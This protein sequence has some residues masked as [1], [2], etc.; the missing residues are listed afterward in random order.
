MNMIKNC[1]LLS[2]NGFFSSKASPVS[3]FTEVASP[4]EQ[5]ALL[6]SSSFYLDGDNNTQKKITNQPSSLDIINT[7]Q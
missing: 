2:Q 3:S 1:N 5:Q 7:T 6:L 4:A